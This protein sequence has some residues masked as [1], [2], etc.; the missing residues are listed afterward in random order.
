MVKEKKIKLR[1]SSLR[2]TRELCGLRQRQLS[3]LRWLRYQAQE[4][5]GR[6]VPLTE[7]RL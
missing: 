2:E 1:E 6:S 5:G 7:A 4:T 3:P